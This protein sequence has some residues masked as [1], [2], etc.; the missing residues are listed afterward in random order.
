VQAVAGVAAAAAGLGI[1]ADQAFPV[2]GEA[3]ALP[4]VGAAGVL[5]GAVLL[6]VDPIAPLRGRRSH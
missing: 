1:L 6:R 3:V 4:T 2:P 5:V